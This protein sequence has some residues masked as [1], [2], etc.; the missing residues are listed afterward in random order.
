ML[1]L[2]SS[3][4]SECWFENITASG[5]VKISVTLLGQAYENLG[6]MEYS[7]LLVFFFK[8]PNLGYPLR[9]AY[10]HA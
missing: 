5:I 4:A 1:D 8:G 3:C 2:I 7:Q 6:T 9:A 10:H